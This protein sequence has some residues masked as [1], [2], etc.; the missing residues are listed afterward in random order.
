LIGISS[1]SPNQ[2]QDGLYGASGLSIL[3]WRE[4]S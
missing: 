4:N 3:A 2:E 1:P